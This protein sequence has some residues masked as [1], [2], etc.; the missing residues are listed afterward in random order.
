MQKHNYT[1]Y[2]DTFADGQ[3][4]GGGGDKSARHIRMMASYFYLLHVSHPGKEQ[5]SLVCSFREKFLLYVNYRLQ[6]CNIPAGFTF[7]SVDQTEKT[8]RSPLQI[9]R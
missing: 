4:V 9:P 6:N 5:F 3:I 8:Q 1:V 2:N 7:L